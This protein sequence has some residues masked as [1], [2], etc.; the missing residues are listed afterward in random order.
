[1][2]A[3]RPGGSLRRVASV[4]FA[5]RV[6]LALAPRS[7]A[8][9]VEKQAGSALNCSEM[10]AP[11]PR[12]SARNA[13][14]RGGPSAQA[15]GGAARGG[16]SHAS[17]G[18]GK[19]DK[20]AGTF[21]LGRYRVVEEIGVGGMASVHLGRMDGPGGFQKWVAIKRIHP[22]LVEDDQFVDMFLDEARIAARHQPRQ[23]GAG[24]RPREGRRHLLDRDGVPP[25]RAAPRG[26]ALHRRGRAPDE[27]R[28]RRP[29][30]RRRGR[31]A[32]RCARAARQERASCWGWCTAT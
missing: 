9:S 12:P 11:P 27:L 32:A 5:E 21:F 15:G 6:G 24:L 18:G 3:R 25:R 13:G 31:G 26:H 2:L 7:L 17:Q 19:G 30:H 28:A 29:H 1:M 16:A 23:R 4:G 10:A 20:A 22:N 14:A 8:K